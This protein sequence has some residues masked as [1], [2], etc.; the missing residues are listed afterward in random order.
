MHMNRFESLDLY[1]SNLF[2]NII[3]S[4]VEILKK[5]SSQYTYLA[6]YD[7]CT[8]CKFVICPKYA[9]KDIAINNNVFLHPISQDENGMKLY[10]FEQ[11]VLSSKFYAIFIERDNS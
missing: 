7:C 9:F 11:Y 1:H 8:H 6:V 4:C 10:N 5:L 3:L 2:L